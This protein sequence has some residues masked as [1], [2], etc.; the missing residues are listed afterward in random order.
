LNLTKFY[1]V[2]DLIKL[3]NYDSESINKNE[4]VDSA[5]KG[6]VDGL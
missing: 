2:Y 6:L 4:L 1:N 5:I 3:N